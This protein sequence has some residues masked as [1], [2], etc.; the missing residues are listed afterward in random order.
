[1]NRTYDFVAKQQRLRQFVCCPNCRSDIKETDASK[2]FDF[3]LSANLLCNKC[4]VVGHVCN[5]RI[6][7]NGENFVRYG[8]TFESRTHIEFIQ[9]PLSFIFENACGNWQASESFAW[10]EKAGAKLCFNTVAVGLNIDLLAH[11]WAG[12][13]EITINDQVIK[14]IDL[15]EPDG[16]MRLSVPLF[17]GQGTHQVALTVTGRKN[18]R[19]NAAQCHVLAVQE[20]VESPIPKDNASVL[21]GNRGNPYPG[22]WSNILAKAPAEALILDCGAGDRCYPDDRVMNFEYCAFG[23]PDIYGDG[24]AIPFKD[25]SFDIVLSQ[26]VFEHLYDPKQ[27]ASEI[28]RILK[29]G[30]FVYVESAFMQ[31]L[32]AVPYHFF[33]TTPWGLEK[34]FENLD[35]DEVESH[36]TLTQTLQWIYSLCDIEGR[37][38]KAKLDTL[39]SLASELDDL[40]TREEMRKF[41]SFVS[42][43]AR[44]KVGAEN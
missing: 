2:V 21:T 13:V 15:F 35:R 37:G 10:S 43:V 36:G 8:K 40:I 26:A 27:A 34:L 25:N 1:M 5:G 29:P 38:G 30:G 20:V 44:K 28:E 31:P 42:L 6:L 11:N 4:G 19:S 16:S 18:P 41:S 17:L 12:I 7:F 9:R 32:H 24:H 33:N 23:L 39:L 3:L 22:V 14:E